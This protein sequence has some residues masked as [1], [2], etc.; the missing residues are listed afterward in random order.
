MQAKADA[1]TDSYHATSQAEFAVGTARA[2]GAAL[3]FALPMLMTMEMWWLGFYMDRL[4]L[5]LFL[6]LLMPMLVGLS[7]WSGFERTGGLTDDVVDAFVAF[8]VAVVV[9][10]VI[11]TMLGILTFAMPR[12]R[13]QCGRR[14][15]VE[16]RHHRH[17]DGRRQ[18]ARGERVPA[19]LRAGAVESHGRAVVHAG[20]GSRTGG[21][22]GAGVCG[23][24]KDSTRLSAETYRPMTCRGVR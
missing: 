18:H 22:A 8:A 16:R 14:H 1:G 9:S 23:A 12:D 4:R 19:R 15:G 10:A 3:I 2:A 5:T 11:L 24:M 17:T 6:L 7:H 21:G 13:A 20:S